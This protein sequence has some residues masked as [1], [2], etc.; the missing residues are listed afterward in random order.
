[1]DKNN[2]AQSRRAGQQERDRSTVSRLGGWVVMS[3]VLYVML[4]KQTNKQTNATRQP[5]HPT[6]KH[7]T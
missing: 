7:G 2:A 6:R 1:M 5:R 3:A 4:N